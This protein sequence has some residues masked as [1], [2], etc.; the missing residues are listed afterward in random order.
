MAVIYA[1]KRNNDMP[2]DYIYSPQG[3]YFGLGKGVSVFVDEKY[4]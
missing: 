1:I 2:H 4:P 3:S